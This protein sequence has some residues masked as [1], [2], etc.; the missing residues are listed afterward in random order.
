LAAKKTTECW[1]IQHSSEPIQI[2]EMADGHY[3]QTD[4]ELDY[5]QSN[6]H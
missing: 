3:G 5:F 6:E 2:T 1:Y 4:I